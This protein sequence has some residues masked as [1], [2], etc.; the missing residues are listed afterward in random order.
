MN[1]NKSYNNK[2]K[3]KLIYKINQTAE[4]FYAF[5]SRKLLYFTIEIP[6]N[7]KQKI[8]LRYYFQKVNL[9]KFSFT[10]YFIQLTIIN[11]IDFFIIYF[12][13]LFIF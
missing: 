5:E 12:K 13:D 1:R 10:L 4:K 9:F 8:L 3:I 7:V 11:L 2:T 6:L